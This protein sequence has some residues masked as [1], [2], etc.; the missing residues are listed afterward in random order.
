VAPAAAP[1]SPA[2]GLASPA[3]PRIDGAYA[4]LVTGIGGT[5]VVTIGQIL[6]MAAHLE[7][8]RVTVLDM[9]GLAQ[10]NGAVMSFVRF[11]EAGEALYAPR[12]GTAA[13]DAVLGCDIVVTAGSDALGRMV[14]DRTRVVANVASTP[15]ADFTRNADL[16]FP[17]DGM[18]AAIVGVVGQ[19]NAAFVD[20]TRLAT[21]LMGDSIATNLFMLGFAWQKGMIPVTS[22]AIE[23]AIELNAVSVE[24]N[25]TAFAW[26]RRAAVDPDGVAQSAAPVAPIRIVP[27]TRKKTADLQ[28]V[29]AIREAS[30]AAY[31]SRR[32]A[33]RYRAL[34]DRV[35]AAERSRIGEGSTRLTRAVAIGYYKLMA[36]KDEYEVARL[37]TD[38]RFEE[39]LAAQFEGDYKLIFNL[40]PPLLARRNAQGELT[41]REFGPWMFG[42]FRMLARLRR[43]RGTPLDIFG[44]TPER[45]MER[46]LI[47]DY[48]VLIDRLVA[49]LD[50][51]RLPIAV[52]LAELPDRIRGFGHVKERHLKDAMARQEELLAQ[53]EG[54]PALAKAA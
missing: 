20:A 44:R 6:G 32:Y 11:A 46:Q 3:L 21:A 37:Y 18:S 5:G 35:A 19:E 23:R 48:E 12:I 26:G 14:A 25:K 15:T 8:K 47:K 27:L 22:A 36:Y 50:E 43:L 13:A 52:E 45:R 28:D 29:I 38:G 54:A 7:G 41:K 40:A 16:Q 30:L 51:V 42:V 9:A 31:Q 33:G 10:K 17:L 2:A 39:R 24:A 53:Y 49:S 1:V 4:L 34:V